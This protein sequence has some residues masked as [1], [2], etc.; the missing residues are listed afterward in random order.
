MFLLLLQLCVCVG[1]IGVGRAVWAS[2]LTGLGSHT[3][4]PHTRHVVSLSFS[5]L[6]YK[7]ERVKPACKTGGLEGAHI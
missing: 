5:F 4:L 3:G 1:G 7:M 2:Q 6:V